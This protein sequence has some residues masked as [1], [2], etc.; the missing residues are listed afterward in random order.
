MYIYVVEMEDP[1]ISLLASY[2]AMVVTDRMKFL[3]KK[4]QV[5]LPTVIILAGFKNS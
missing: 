1:A 5:L 2:L 3:L 4:N